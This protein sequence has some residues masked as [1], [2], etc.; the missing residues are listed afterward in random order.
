MSDVFYTLVRTI[1]R[2]VFW[3]ASRETFLHAD[4]LDATGG[5]MIIV[6]NHLSSYDVPCIMAATRR[7]LDFV[8]IVE[9]F[10]NPLAA[11]FLR[12]MN[13]FPLDRGRADPATTRT[14]LDR[15][16]RGRRIVMFPEG[17]I[18]TAK[19]SLLAGGSFKPSVTRLARVANV[20]II[21]CVV[22]AT[23]AFARPAAW[24]PLKRTRYAIGFAEPITVADEPDEPRAV[25]RMKEAYARL[26]TEL[27]AASGL[28]LNDSPWRPERTATANEVKP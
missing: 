2:P 6:P 16:A 25:D 12:G 7:R 17:R 15:L 4:R 28:T 5:G 22:L 1:G 27:G 26:Y 9:I 19:T 3:I 23:G 14:I 13:A 10:R 8:S 11:W 24:L 20:P 18:R 21:P